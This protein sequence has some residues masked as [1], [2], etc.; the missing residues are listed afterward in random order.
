MAIGD[1]SAVQS[2]LLG[3]ALGLAVAACGARSSLE[4]PAG[5]AGAGGAATG[6]APTGGAGGTGAAAGSGG[7]LVGGAACNGPVLVA[8]VV[9]L[10][11][12]DEHESLEP[13]MVVASDDGEQVMFAV[14]RVQW[15]SPEPFIEMR[16]GAFQ[17]WTE[18]PASGSA[19][20]PFESYASAELVPPFFLADSLGDEAAMF[21]GHTFS[22]SLSPH[23]DPLASGGSPTYT[24][25]GMRPVF[26]AQNG[27]SWLLGARGPG[28]ELHLTR[29]AE[30]GQ[31]V[32]FETQDIACSGSSELASAVPFEDGFLV[33][34]ANAP[35]NAPAT[36]EHPE[37]E[38]VATR[39]DVSSLHP[40]EAPQWWLTIDWPTPYNRVLAVPHP[41]GVWVVFQAVS[42]DD[43]R[44]WAVRLHLPEGSV[45]GPFQLS[46]DEHAPD[47]VVAAA[48]G[49]SLVTAWQSLPGSGAPG[50]ELRVIDEMGV[51]TASLA[52]PE[53]AGLQG[54][55]A[56]VS[57]E[58]HGSVVF[59]MESGDP[60]RAHMARV[61]CLAP[62]GP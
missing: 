15:T 54:P 52:L 21:V 56:M 5:A 26:V 10:E 8:P 28:T 51:Q 53:L 45:F 14:R 13:E 39:F 6:G 58:A 30:K 49:G 22:T 25:Q 35:S 42:G 7:A 47:R 1:R 44:L 46:E 36:C 60:V 18:W 57:S 50:V 19:A 12:D 31:V 2:V 40:G 11:E 37:D 3:S 16:H 23:M 41:G 62:P 24:P 34:A 27:S 38:S 43:R 55:Q 20:A 59:S 32:E 33:A 29:I 9:T 61:D 4:L 48:L 17:P